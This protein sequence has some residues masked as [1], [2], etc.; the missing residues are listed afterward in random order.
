MNSSKKAFK[1]GMWYTISN[2]LVKSIA[3]ITTPIFTRLLTKAEYGIYNNY[4]SWLGIIS[5]FVTL[6]LESTLISARYDYEKNLDEYIFS[7]LILSSISSFIWFVITNI[8]PDFFQNIFG[9]DQIY[10]NTMLIYLLMLP[11]VN[12]FQAR[13]RYLFKYKSTVA[14]SLVIA[15]STVI[16]SVTLVLLMEDMLLGRILGA[17]SPTIILGLG[18]YIYFIAKGRRIS[19]K[20]W[21]YAVP[22][23]LPYIPHLL[24]LNVLNSLDRIM[25]TRWCGK[26]YTA[27]YS[28][29]YTCG[30]MITLL[31]TSMNSAFAPWLGEKLAE[32]NLKEVRKI[33][34]IYTAG[35]F[36]LSTGIMLI[37][38]EVLLILGG[39]NYID[40]VYV[41]APISMGCICQFFYTMFVN[42]EQF[43]KKTIGMAFASTFAAGL[44]II[45]NWIFI[46]KM[47]YYAA[48]YTT[49][50]GYIFLLLIHMFLVQKMKFA[51]VYDYK[52]IMFLVIIGIALTVLISILYA[53]TILRYLFIFL[54][55]FV[56][57][58]I[59]TKNVDKIAGFIKEV[60]K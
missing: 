20:Y 36:F 59:I 32:N 12:M 10:I 11:A 13:E 45:L 18:F 48:A 44:N 6:N 1:S 43:Q 23:C 34:Y 55:L 9:L 3:F 41:L 4:I 2:F 54:Y 16:L 22:I 26:E 28:I 29:A 14:A 38:P 27:I 33:S 53:H 15:V 50:A 37:S 51:E 25:I 30:M 5:I 21:I 46:P 31:M 40:A 17:V 8:F 60:K 56:L 42:V 7:V 57:I 49:L 24:S 39:K 19:L 52:Y 35:F 47:G 58:R